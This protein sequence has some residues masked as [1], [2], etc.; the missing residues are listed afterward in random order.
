M[1]KVNRGATPRRNL[2]RHLE[3]YTGSYSSYMT[4]ERRIETI[5]E[6]FSV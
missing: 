3:A 1:T 5:T 2:E 6:I 4:C